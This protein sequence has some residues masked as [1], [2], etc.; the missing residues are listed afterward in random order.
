MQTIGSPI[1]VMRGALQHVSEP[2]TR[3][4]TH[5]YAALAFSTG[6]R[7]RIELSG[8]W[9][10]GPGDCLLVPA[11]Q[12]HRTLQAEDTQLWGVGFC[13]PCLVAE[14]VG[15]L[16]EPFERVRDGASAVVS[17]P[18]VRQAYLT[19]LFQELE[20]VEKELIGL[21]GSREVVQRSLLT[22]I[23]AEVQRATQAQG[24]RGESSVVTEALRYIE[25]HCLRALSLGE[26]AAAVGRSPAHV[27]SLLTQSTGRSVGQWIVS[28]RMAEARRLLLHSEER[29]E[30]IAER[31]GYADV[32]H[33]I[34]MFRREQ[35][36]TPAAWRQARRTASPEVNRV[37]RL[38]RAKK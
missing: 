22:L 5:S 8:E 38:S 37:N 29:V 4:V 32:T 6:G 31:V 28:G 2:M 25:R 10:L 34:R 20:S 12:P 21:G 11:G 3:P 26:V 30:K 1:V 17:I 18:E 19:G 33:F 9:E 27:T 7:S 23:L 35:G 14:G 24:G 13:V 36:S 16:L 15:E